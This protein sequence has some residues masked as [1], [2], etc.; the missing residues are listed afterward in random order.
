[1]GSAILMRARRVRPLAQ[2]IIVDPS[3]SGWHYSS[4]PGAYAKPTQS[5]PWK[6]V[7]SEYRRQPAEPV[8]GL[9][10]PVIMER[11]GAAGGLLR[12]LSSGAAP[13]NGASLPSHINKEVRLQ[14]QMRRWGTRCK[15][16]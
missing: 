3:W 15:T 4:M 14:W 11:T 5:H 1:M 8:V 16:R 6:L 9:W 7:D 2:R 13:G 10:F 12:K